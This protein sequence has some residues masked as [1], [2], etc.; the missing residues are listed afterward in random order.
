MRAAGGC[1]SQQ[2]EA[3]EGLREPPLPRR[4]RREVGL[5]ERTR[6]VYGVSERPRGER[7][8]PRK[9]G[10]RLRRQPGLPSR[11]GEHPVDRPPGT[12]AVELCGTDELGDATE[13]EIGD[14]AAVATG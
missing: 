12:W 1:P 14:K 6:P 10:L 11:R 9:T 4:L 3:T 2:R 7:Q 8:R 5:G 13:Q